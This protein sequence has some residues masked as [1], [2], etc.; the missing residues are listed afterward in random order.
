MLRI[1][2][3]VNPIIVSDTTN[4]IAPT[5]ITQHL[6]LMLVKDTAKEAIV[7]NSK[8]YAKIP[9]VIT[10][11]GSEYLT[12][13]KISKKQIKYNTDMLINNLLL[14]T[15]ILL[16]FSILIN[17]QI[18]KT[19]AIPK[20][21]IPPKKRAGIEITSPKIKSPMKHAKTPSTRYL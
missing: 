3:P 9:D 12:M 15:L 7:L 20:A 14:N 16:A 2:N 21:A 13:I 18:K 11:L 4:K 1:P 6:T 10:I 17:T 8:E 5:A 19:W